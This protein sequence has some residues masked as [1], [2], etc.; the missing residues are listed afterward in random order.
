MTKR[1]TSTSQAG[2]SPSAGALSAIAE[3]VK[4]AQKD[5]QSSHQWASLGE[6]VSLGGLALTLLGAFGFAN[7][8]AYVG[9]YWSDHALPSHF[10]LPL[11]DVIYYGFSANIGT[12]GG[13]LLASACAF[14]VLA[15]V[16]YLGDKVASW[17]E[18]NGRRPR[19]LSSDD[20]MP[21]GDVAF[22]VKATVVAL[23]LFSLVVALA[24]LLSFASKHARERA[25]Q[26]RK[27]FSTWDARA[28]AELNLAL[29]VVSTALP[30]QRSKQCGFVVEGSDKFIALSD[31]VS[32]QIVPIDKDAVRIRTWSL[33]LHEVEA[34]R[35][36]ACECGFK[37]TPTEKCSPSP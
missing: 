21:R 32:A 3:P 25:D 24:I 33:R 34:R 28:M 13:T 9:T 23:F 10:T 1:A 30:D 7:G 12:L 18:R 16:A 37:T 27:A 2:A 17:L 31:G 4:A 20:S 14:A 22:L 29:A 5:V 26:E 36:A 11:H 8:R 6:W 35:V 19:P 15:A